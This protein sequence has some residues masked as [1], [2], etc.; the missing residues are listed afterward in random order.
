MAAI[1]ALLDRSISA[2]GF[3]VREELDADFCEV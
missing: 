2:D 1:N 3:V